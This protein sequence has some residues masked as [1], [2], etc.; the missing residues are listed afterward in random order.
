MAKRTPPSLARLKRVFARQRDAPWDARYQPGIC[1]TREEAPSISRAKLL[2]SER[3]GRAIHLMS[4]PEFA[5]CLLG[6]YHPNTV[7]LQ[8]QRALWPD[9]SPHPLANFPG[10]GSA[11][12]AGLIGLIDV[13]DRLGFLEHLSYIRV[14][15][16]LPDDAPVDVPFP[17]FG[18]LLWALRDDSKRIV[19]I[20]W[21]VKDSHKAFK[22]PISLDGTRRANDAERIVARHRIQ[23]EYYRDAGIR[24][25]QVAFEDL[26]LNVVANLRQLFGHQSAQTGLSGARKRE[27]LY[28][29]RTALKVGEPPSEVLIDFVA[30]RR[31]TREQFYTCFHQVVWERDLRLD[32]FTPIN[33]DR[34]LHAETTDVLDVYADLFKGD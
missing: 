2:F 4:T 20:D 7:G 19:A 8:E 3:L 32:L 12:L 31:C 15:G 14:P 26:D 25:L 18:D 16:E 27:I 34:P 11:R 24:S 21:N 28:A 13:A 9:P 22:Q 17:W 10:C 6:L 30:R 1:A 5:F 23:E 33:F 29:L